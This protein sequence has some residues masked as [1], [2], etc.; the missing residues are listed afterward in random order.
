MLRRITMNFLDNEGIY[1][2]VL[3]ENQSSSQSLIKQEW[4]SEQSLYDHGN[5]LNLA[6]QLLIETDKENFIAIKNS[7]KQKELSDRKKS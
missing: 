4:D 2:K 1:E 6:I 7:Q 3:V 5:I